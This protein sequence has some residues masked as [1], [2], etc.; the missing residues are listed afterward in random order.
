MSSDST[1]DDDDNGRQSASS[2]SLDSIVERILEDAAT[3]AE[4]KR[5]SKRKAQRS[6]VASNGVDCQGAKRDVDRLNRVHPD[7]EEQRATPSDNE[8]HSKPQHNGIVGP[9][10]GAKSRRQRHRRPEKTLEDL[11]E[12]AVESLRDGDG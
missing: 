8:R 2:E 11:F 6:K 12:E 10:A 3:D 1:N 7:N 9:S 5:W 4:R